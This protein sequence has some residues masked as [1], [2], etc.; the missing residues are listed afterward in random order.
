MYGRWTASLV[1]VALS[2]ALDVA[3]APDAAAS[4]RTAAE[5]EALRQSALEHFHEGA[6]STAIEEM[7]RAYGLV[8][9]PSLLFNI[10]VIYEQWSGHCVEALQAFDQYA[11]VCRSAR[12]SAVTE[13]RERRAKVDAG[14][15]C[16][17]LIETKP[18]GA[19][20]HIDSAFAGTSPLR[21][22][23]KPGKHEI[24]VGLKDHQSHRETIELGEGEQRSRSFSLDLLAPVAWLSF[25]NPPP[26]VGI[27]VDG[28]EVAIEEGSPVSVANGPHRIEVRLGARVVHSMDT[29][30]AR[31]ETAVIDLAPIHVTVQDAIDAQ[32]A[33]RDSMGWRWGLVGVGGAGILAGVV[34]SGLE[35]SQR[36]NH[37]DAVAR[38]MS[39]LETREAVQSI[40][41][42]RQ[43]MRVGLTT[44]YAIG[45]ALLVS[46]LVA[47]L[48][49]DTA[50]ADTE[51]RVLPA[52]GPNTL[53]VAGTF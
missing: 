17:L 48:V 20:V 27:F 26:N 11:A 6:I 31:T 21:A 4:K 44:S 51:V 47:M 9:T 28:V 52:I 50:A 18:P 45:G 14:C 32:A 23:V 29:D 40:A 16:D 1:I 36:A 30:V 5:A 35:A 22:R 10:A 42:T 24:A 7:R 25:Q 37:E 49:A 8:P 41:D 34:L 46:G 3:G 43:A 19:S 13:A 15:L 53:G 39:G 2:P 12:C 33:A 38:A